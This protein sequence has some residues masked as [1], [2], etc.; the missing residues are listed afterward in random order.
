[1][2]SVVTD[3]GGHT[4]TDTSHSSSLMEVGDQAVEDRVGTSSEHKILAT[5]LQTQTRLTRGRG[6][7]EVR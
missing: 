7:T 5:S 6:Q 1:M 2:D 3:D 4:E